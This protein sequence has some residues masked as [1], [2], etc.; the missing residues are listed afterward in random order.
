MM[1]REEFE[2]SLLEYGTLEVDAQAERL[3]MLVEAF[4][5]ALEDAVLARQ[6]RDDVKEKYMRDFLESNKEEAETALS[7]DALT[8]ND[9]PEEIIAV[10]EY[11]DLG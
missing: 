6:E 7:D 4:S 3:L 10:D 8:D 11:M 1:T 9:A 2:N 5:A